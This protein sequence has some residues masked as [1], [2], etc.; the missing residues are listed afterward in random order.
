M[1]GLD[2]V[3]L[4]RL[5]SLSLTPSASIPPGVREGFGNKLAK[6]SKNS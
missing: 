1:F 6:I 3:R 4:D 2:L 5:L